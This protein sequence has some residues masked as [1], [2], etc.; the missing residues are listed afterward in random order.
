MNTLVTGA[1]GFIGSHLCEALAKSNTV[2]GIDNFD[3]YYDIRLK[4]KNLLA[5]SKNSK[6]KLCNV[7]ILNTEKLQDVMASWKFDVIFHLAALAGVRPSIKDPAR[8]NN[9]NVTGT[10]NLLEIAKERKLKRIIFASSSSVYGNTN[11]VPFSEVEEDL[12]PISPYGATKLAAEHTLRVY[13]KLFDFRPTALRF[14]TCYGP[15]QRPDMA[16]H[17]FTRLISEGKEIEIYGDSTLRDYTYVDDVIS[18]VVNCANLDEHFEV[19]NIGNSKPTEIANVINILEQKIGK[20]AV[21]RRIAEQPGDVKQTFADIS[22]ASSRLGF[23]PKITIK[24]GLEKFVDWYKEI[25]Q[26]QSTN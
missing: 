24:D 22:K 4:E 14:F 1:A 2:I 16:I 25:F 11:N 23:Y 19:Y 20:K 15:R 17:K 26:K 9:V 3:P 13:S 8:Y 21:I 18:A 5:L 10:I 12:Q 7:D 6:F